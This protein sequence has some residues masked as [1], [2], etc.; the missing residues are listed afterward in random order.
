MSWRMD[1]DLKQIKVLTN[2][3]ILKWGIVI[4]KSEKALAS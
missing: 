3:K 1:K 4:R 2:W